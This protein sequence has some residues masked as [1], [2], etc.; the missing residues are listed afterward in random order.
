V[1]ELVF[2]KFDKFVIFGTLKIDFFAG[3][4]ASKTSEKA[5]E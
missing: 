3:K 4:I 2:K 5:K 1:G